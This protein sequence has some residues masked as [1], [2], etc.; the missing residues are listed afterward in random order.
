MKKK[1]LLILTVICFVLPLSFIFAGC[2]SHQHVFGE[3]QLK[4]LASCTTSEIHHRICSCGEEQTRE[5]G[6]PLPHISSDWIVDQDSTCTASGSKHKECTVCEEELETDIIAKKEHSITEWAEVTPA[7]CENAQVLERHCTTC[8]TKSETKEGTA[9]LGHTESDW[10]VDQDSTCTASGSKHKECTVCEEELATD[11][12][13]KKEH[14]MT[15]WAEVTP[16]D[17]EN[18]QVLE[19]HCTTCTTKSETKEGTAAL[20]HTE[21]G[22]IVETAATC[23]SYGVSYK[24][25]TVCHKELERDT[26]VEKLP[27]TSS[28]WIVD[29]DSTCTA[30][31]SKHKECTVCEEELATDIIAKKEHNYEETIIAPTLS[32]VGYTKHKCSNC[33]NSYNDTESYLLTFETVISHS[34]ESEGQAAPTLTT[35]QQIVYKDDLA[36]NPYKFTNVLENDYYYTKS[37]NVTPY[38]SFT[39]TYA[40]GEEIAITK[41]T[42]IQIN[43]RGLKNYNSKGEGTIN[44]PYEI[45]NVYQLTNLS[46]VSPVA[47]Y[48]YVQTSDIDLSGIE[49]TPIGSNN[50]VSCFYGY[51]NGQNYT[52]SNMS[53][54]NSKAQIIG[55][56]ATISGGSICNLKLVNPSISNPSN[57]NGSQFIGLLS[58]YICNEATIS[59]IQITSTSGITVSGTYTNSFEIGGLVA[60]ISDSVIECCSVD[61]PIIVT[62]YNNEVTIGGLVA[63]STNS[64]ITQ[65][66]SHGSI[67]YTQ[68]KYKG[69]TSIA[70]LIGEVIGGEITNCY[71]TSEVRFNGLETASDS[72]EYVAGLVAVIFEDYDYDSLAGVTTYY[73]TNINNNYYYGDI[74]ITNYVEENLTSGMLFGHIYVNDASKDYY[75][76]SNN[77]AVNNNAIAISGTDLSTIT[78]AINNK[79]M[80]DAEMIIASR[81]S[82]LDSNIWLV[83]SGESPKLK[84]ET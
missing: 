66:V 81:W 50:D 68:V 72:W 13:A 67:N 58:G 69:S 70:G 27:H 79:S 59:N 47:A 37:I 46:E 41:S 42:K 31:G 48:Y 2:S 52:I 39:Q 75:Y 74:A 30:S 73:E 26:Q 16:A 28:D 25:C 71:S 64:T 9:A 12:I 23:S 55:L 40:I 63:Q 62:P 83:E 45:D 36:Q 15:E 56:F 32:S 20:G 61:A 77:V 60:S 19:R 1:I 33:T 24:E 84:F 14:S 51:Y 22:W 35:T 17:C 44:S 7:D 34:L 18:A 4:E 5:V 53:I 38:Q 21:S 76:I 11:T 29:Q 8:T 3:W 82:H 49:W 10:I 6:E 43:I 57:F 54:N 80:T 65:S 78:N